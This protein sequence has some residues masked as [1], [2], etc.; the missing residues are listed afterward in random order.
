MRKVIY[1][2]AASLDGFIATSEGGVEWLKMQDLEEGAEEMGEFFSGIDT[3]LY[4]RKTFEKGLEM[5]DSGTEFKGIRN[6]VFSRSKTF[7]PIGNVEFV[8]GDAA[9]YVRNLKEADGKNILLMGG[10]EI[11]GFFMKKGL[12]DELIVGIQPVALG[13]GIPLF[14]GPLEITELERTGVKLRRSGTVQVSYRDI[15]PDTD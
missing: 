4:G 6:V 5:D 12:I 14:S 8:E 2:L 15:S 1:A 3:I 13:D 9:E 7:A 10:G 11:A